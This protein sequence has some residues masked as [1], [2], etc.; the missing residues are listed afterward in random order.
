V[1]VAGPGSP[2]RAFSLAELLVVIAIIGILAAIGIPALRG[3]GESNAIDA[4]T[5]Q[6]LDDLAYARLRAINDRSTVFMLFVPPDVHQQATNLVPYRMTGYSLFTR[7]SVGE[8]PGRQSPRQLIP[9][10]ALPD[11]TFFSVSKFLQP[12][13]VSGT[14][15]FEHPFAW[16]N[17]FPLI[18][19]NRIYPFM[20]MFYLAFNARGQVVRFDPAGR[21]VAGAD[22]FIALS[23]GSILHP[24]E[25]DGRYTEPPDVVE[26]PRG[27]R[28]YLRV[29]WLT[30]RAEVLGDL[31]VLDDGTGR[32]QGQPE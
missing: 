25:P 15:Q 4:A 29:N 32:I 18:I 10:R 17:N 31:V 9:W 14:N 21:Q 24:Q 16:T 1:A 30:G 22:E 26:V 13:A 19:T 3:L 7:R 5:R 2:A 20:G 8:Q 28:R 27:N 23:R 11:K 12:G 6:M